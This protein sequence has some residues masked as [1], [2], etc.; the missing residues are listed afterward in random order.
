MERYWVIWR[1]SCSEAQ[2]H[3]FIYIAG[4]PFHVFWCCGFGLVAFVFVFAFILGHPVFCAVSALEQL[5]INWPTML[6]ARSAIATKNQSQ[7]LNQLVDMLS[8]TSQ[9]PHEC[10]HCP[11]ERYD[12]QR[13]TW[14]PVLCLIY[15][16]CFW[17]CWFVGYLCFCMLG[18]VL[19]ATLA[20]LIKLPLPRL[21]HF[22][23]MILIPI[24]PV[25]SPE[26]ICL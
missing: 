26:K 19:G 22:Q 9:S 11:L 21:V 23:D 20:L 7:V 3:C 17:C 5:E 13:N 15:V 12:P 8:I 18:V 14:R 24:V 25:K 10:F 4:C 2:F 1:I 6:Q 16:V